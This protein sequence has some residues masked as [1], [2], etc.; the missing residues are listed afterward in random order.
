MKTI[1]HWQAGSAGEKELLRRCKEAVRR[2]APSARLILYGSRARGDGEPESDYDLLVLLGTPAT[3]EDERLVSSTIYRIER[4][5]G[6]VISVQI[7][8][9][10]HWE[11][12]RLRS[13]PLHQHVD[14]DGVVI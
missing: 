14:R 13:I 4:D 9:Q 5:A 12:R 1:D 7:Y 11:S 2:V 8:Q 10:D 3:E 6:V